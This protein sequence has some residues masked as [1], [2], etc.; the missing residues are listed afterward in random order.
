MKRMQKENLWNPKAKKCASCPELKPIKD[1]QKNVDPHK[2][3]CEKWKWEIDNDLAQKQ[4]VCR[5][6]KP[7]RRKR[8]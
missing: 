1:K 6:E 3:L 5:I 4:A 8:K 2:K 7:K